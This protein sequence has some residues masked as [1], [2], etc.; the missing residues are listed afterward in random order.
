MHRQPLRNQLKLVAL[1]CQERVVFERLQ[2]H[3]EVGEAL[4]QVEPLKKP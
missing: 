2:G 3:H 1:G 4:R